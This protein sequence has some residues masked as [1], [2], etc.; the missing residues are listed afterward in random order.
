M[1]GFVEGSQCAAY[2]RTLSFWLH[3]NIRFQGHIYKISNPI[4]KGS[5]KMVDDIFLHR[6]HD[7]FMIYIYTITLNLISC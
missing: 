2:F 3:Y 5:R 6:L 4:F 7:G 1:P